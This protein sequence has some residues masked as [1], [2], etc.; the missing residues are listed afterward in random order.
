MIEV[1]V[2]GTKLNYFSEC[3][4]Y[5]LLL[6]LT[7]SRESDLFCAADFDKKLSTSRVPKFNYHLSVGL[8]TT[9]FCTSLS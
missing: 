1:G 9:Y 2:E 7:S 3:C 4:V 6:F 8:H 5:F